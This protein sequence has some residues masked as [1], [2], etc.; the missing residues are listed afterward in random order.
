MLPQCMCGECAE[1]LRFQS[2]KCPIC[3]HAVE[4][5]LQ[6]KISQRKD[7]TPEDL[8]AANGA[9]TTAPE[10]ATGTA[11][12]TATATGTGTDIG[13]STGTG[14]GTGA[15]GG[16][17]IEDDS[18]V[19]LSPPASN[20][21]PSV[22]PGLPLDDQS[23]EWPPRVV[24]PQAGALGLSGADAHPTESFTPPAAGPGGN[25]VGTQGDWM[26]AGPEGGQ[27]SGAGVASAQSQASGPATANRTST[28]PFA[29]P[30]N[31]FIMP[32]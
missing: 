8:L 17:L 31:S 1:V 16:S 23:V 27:F 11:A 2:N 19:P 13:T 29:S 14:M 25:P 3:R 18:L 24:P 32:S 7:A 10:T 30:T 20:P 26:G 5:L 6:I 4:G 12:G 21:G 28:N 22:G 9:P 15:G